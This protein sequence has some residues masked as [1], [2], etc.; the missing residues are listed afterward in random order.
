MKKIKQLLKNNFV[1]SIL[2]ISGG[3][4]FAQIF[5]GA[6]SPIITRIYSPEDYGILTLYTSILSI[7]AI[8]GSLQ[9]ELSIPIAEDEEKAINAFALSFFIL[10]IVT[11]FFFFIIFFFN[12][13]FLNI[14][15][16]SKLKNYSFLIPLGIFLIGLYN[17]FMQW[18][19]RKKDYKSISKT[20]ISQSFV[21]NIL[22]IILGLLKIGPVG[23]ILGRILGQSAG[24]TTLSK[25]LL[26][27]KHIFKKVSFKK[28]FW[29][30]QRYKNFLIFSTPTQFLNTLGLQLPV[31]FLSAFFSET[32]IGFYGLANSIV[33][34]PMAIIGRSV[35]DVFYGEAASIGKKNPKRVKE[36]SNKLL[37]KLII[38]GLIPLIILLFFGPF[39]FSFVFGEQWFESGIYARI[40][41][42]L[43]FF[44]LIF[45]PISR[46]YSVFEKQNIQ[47]FLILIRLV[48]L[49]FSFSVSYFLKLNSYNTILMYT[50]TSSFIYF[51][52]YILAQN[53]LNK[54]IENKASE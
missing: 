16:A 25:S 48:L 43:V 9:Y 2:M 12:N 23:L 6:M 29:I 52:G 11:L 7:L 28:M 37:K 14:F 47:F 24:T 30:G 33:Q 45:T 5:N 46:V 54:E 39:L 22:K 50:I 51:L 34:L 38:I 32:I 4:A 8:I 53:I 42:F 31:F 20:K 1:K 21:Q 27:E 35:G 41:S 13:I 36:L 15:D 17:I 26:K 10:F 19:F 3:T 40:I 44:Q 18:A 49:G